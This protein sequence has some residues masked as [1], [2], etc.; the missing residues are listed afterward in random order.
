VVIGMHSK[1]TVDSCKVVKNVVQIINHPSYN[2]KTMRN[3]ISL[4]KLDSPVEEYSPIYDLD[5]S[6]GED[7]EFEAAGQILTVAGWGTLAPCRPGAI[8]PTYPWKSICP[9][10]A[11][12]YVK[13]NIPMRA[14]HQ[15]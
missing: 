13:H 5:G 2:S 7:P 11:R 14:S 12:M 10:S 1:T 8:I 15:I 3:D 9:W 6:G 4:L